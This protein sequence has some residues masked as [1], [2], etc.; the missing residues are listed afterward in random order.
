MDTSSHSSQ[1]HHN[2]EPELDLSQLRSSRANRESASSFN[3]SLDFGR[4]SAI[5]RQRKPPSSTNNSNLNRSKDSFEL[6]GDSYATMGDSFMGESF[7]HLGDQSFAL[8]NGDDCFDYSDSENDNELEIVARS[9]ATK[10]PDL[11]TVLDL[12]E[13]EEVIESSEIDC[14]DKIRIK[15]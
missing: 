9:N 8:G 3:K 2:V 11:D 1:N 7:A 6:F 13:E 15:K 4:H 12:E 10:R 14:E 5:P